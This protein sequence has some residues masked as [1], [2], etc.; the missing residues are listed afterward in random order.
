MKQVMK[1]ITV[2]NFVTMFK[3]NY[4]LV[5]GVIYSIPIFHLKVMCSGEAI[6]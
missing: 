1:V 2:L 6:N 4:N 3:K 5:M